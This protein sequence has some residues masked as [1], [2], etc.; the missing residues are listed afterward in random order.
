GRWSF[1]QLDLLVDR[2][3][4]VPRPETEVVAL[5]ALDE[6][7]RLGARR[8]VRN[9]WMGT[10]VVFP[11]ADLGTGSGALALTL[12][13]EL[14]DAEGWATDGSE[15]ALAVARANL[16]GIGRAATRVRLATGSWFDALPSSLRG[17]L[18]I[19]VSNPPYI[20]EREVDTLPD[21]VV[22][23]EPYGALVAGPTGL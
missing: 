11:V 5:A 8:G 6:A 16:A 1:L 2:R 19:V 7:T 3:V 20:A 4:L 10:D 23:W 12:A 17:T 15:H 18:R 9:A 13:V 22:S 14:P 21:A